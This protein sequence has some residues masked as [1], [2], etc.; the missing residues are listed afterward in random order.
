MNKAV[1]V[2]G[3][4][5]IHRPFDDLGLTY[6]RRPL[7][8][9]TFELE[10]AAIQLL[11]QRFA[12]RIFR[13]YRRVT[14]DGLELVTLVLRFDDETFV[15]A[16]GNYSQRGEVY[17][18]S[19]ERA[20]AVYR[21]IE[22]ILKECEAT[23]KPAFFMLR[24]DGSEISAE[25]ITDVPQPL[26]NDLMRLYYGQDIDEW[27]QDF[28]QRTRNKIG[29]ITILEGAPGTGKTTL[30]SQLVVRLA[31][32]HVFYVLPVGNDAALTSAELVPF[33]VGQNEQH[34]DKVKVI[35]M[36]DAERVLLRRD[37]DNQNSISALLNIADGLMGRMLRLHL[38]CSLNGKLEE[39]D[40]AI[41]R[42][43]RLL[44]HRRFGLLSK[45][46]ATAIAQARGV[47]FEPACGRE[48]FTLAEVLNPS[49]V[50]RPSQEV[51]IGF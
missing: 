7:Y 50:K 22:P 43:G 51:R 25:E 9:I 37:A 40:P 1:T 14:A 13:S 28:E 36:E 5:D 11:A 4:F 23:S 44:N 6:A 41:L 15:M 47:S 18:A 27:I 2:T 8:R 24:Y 19:A 35:V 42:P 46:N 49:V 17:A 26:A 29:G 20:E 34:P 33:W 39:I 3:E 48:G 38:V 21:Q 16:M 30:V 10:Q 12:D 32:S 31:A 45:E